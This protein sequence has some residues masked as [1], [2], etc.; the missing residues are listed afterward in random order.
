MTMPDRN[1]LHSELSENAVI[2]VPLR[3]VGSMSEEHVRSELDAVLAQV[4][5]SGA[6]NVVV[7]FAHLPYFG[8]AML[9]VMLAIWRR[10]RTDEGKMA[11]CNASE[12]EREVLRISAF[13]SLWPMC[14]T[15]AEAM[16]SFKE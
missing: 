11:V 6:K 2:V 15:R 14:S 8:S 3:D 5:A 7:D 12:M 13:D 1:V 9:E 16:E 4:Q 10:V